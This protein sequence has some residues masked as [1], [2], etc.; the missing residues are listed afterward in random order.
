MSRWPVVGSNARPV[1]SLVKPS[2]LIAPLGFRVPAVFSVNRLFVPKNGASSISE[3]HRK[4][5]SRVGT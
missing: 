1:G 4:S 3:S 5:V 2:M